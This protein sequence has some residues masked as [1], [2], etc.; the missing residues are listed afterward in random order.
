MGTLSLIWAV[1][2]ASFLTVLI[3]LCVCAFRCCGNIS[4]EERK[5]SERRVP[6]A[7]SRFENSLMDDGYGGGGGGG[8]GTGQRLGTE[9]GSQ[10]Q[11]SLCRS[12]RTTH[13][14][15]NLNNLNAIPIDGGE[16]T[17]AN[18]ASLNFMALSDTTVV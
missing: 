16:R 3:T 1:G 6:I 7:S 15:P 11:R 13:I 18:L 5:F 8:G 14:S 2:V 12:P 10:L 9:Y 17:G 4:P